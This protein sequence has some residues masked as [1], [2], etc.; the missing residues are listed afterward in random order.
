[1]PCSF[2][3][4]DKQLA[5]ISQL[6]S[7]KLYCFEAKTLNIRKHGLWR[8]YASDCRIVFKKSDQ[9]LSLINIKCSWFETNEYLD[10]KILSFS[11]VEEYSF[12]ATNMR[13]SVCLGE[14]TVSGID[15]YTRSYSR[16]KESASYDSFVVLKTEKNNDIL[17][18]TDEDIS[19]NIFL[20][21]VSE[22]QLLSYIEEQKETKFSEYDIDIRRRVHLGKRGS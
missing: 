17:L 18:G 15:I 1:M 4:D 12:P 22:V 13:N 14:E 8:A 6:T 11:G 19:D 9:L 21:R 3:L 2:L 10:T 7:V 20:S 5:S 16:D